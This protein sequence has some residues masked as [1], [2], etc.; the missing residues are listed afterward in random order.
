M[1]GSAVTGSLTDPGD[2][3]RLVDHALERH[4]RIDA[5]VNGAGHARND[6]L[7]EVTDQDWR[8]G[9]DML[10]LSVVRMARLVTPHRS[11]PEAAPSSTSPRTRPSSRSASSRSTPACGPRSRASPSCTPTSTRPRTSG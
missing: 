5:V 6:A 2:L 1:G 11:G 7:L 4:G 10:F 8:D 3:A 9:L